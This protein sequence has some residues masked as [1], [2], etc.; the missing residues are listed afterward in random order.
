MYSCNNDDDNVE[1][2]PPRDRGEEAIRA[3]AEIEGFLQTHFYNYEE[4]QNAGSNPDFDF[5]VR[6]DSIAGDNSEKTP[7]IEQ[8]SSIVVRDRIDTSVEYKLYYL[9]AAEG[10]SESPNFCDAVTT[11][12]RGTSLG[13]ETFDSSATAVRLDLSQTITGFQEI[14]PLFKGAGTVNT[15]P[16]GTFSFENFGVGAVFV[17]SGLAYYQS[18]SSSISAYE[19]LIF[20]FQ[21]FAT[22]ILDHDG[23]G[24]PSFMEDLNGNKNLLDDNTDIDSEPLGNRVP[25]YLDVD[26]D[27][28]GRLTRDEIRIVGGNVTFPDSNGDG[29]PDYLDPNI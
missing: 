18:G 7:L 2:T 13:L 1:I 25:N 27:G 12:Y 28:D 24:I 20:T 9:K 10:Q 4:F 26:D 22:E 16:D 8:V 17:P 23:D 15:N 5:Q 6:F 19:Q 3:Q 29:I 14:Y 11:N 21:V